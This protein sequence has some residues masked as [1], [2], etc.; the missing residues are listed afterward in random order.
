MKKNVF[1]ITALMAAMM[2]TMM[3][4]A[5][6]QDWGGRVIDEKG[7]PMPFVNV[8]LLSLPDSTF[9]QGAMTDMDGVFKI[10]TDVN[11]GLFKVTSV[12]YQ[13]LYINAGNDLTIQM[14][15]DT[16]LLKEVVVKGQMPKTHVKG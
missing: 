4:S 12:G 10:V 2:M 15:E 3:S 9:V 11:E 16:Q 8:V 7:E 13:T 1:R 14:K 5:K 6:T